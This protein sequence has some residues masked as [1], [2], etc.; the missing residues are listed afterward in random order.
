MKLMID[1]YEESL[2]GVYDLTLTIGLQDYASVQTK[3][4]NTF[5][6]TLYKID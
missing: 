2:A 6:A 1:V 3:T 5:K 4:T